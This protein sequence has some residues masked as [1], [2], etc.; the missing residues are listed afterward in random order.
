MR[1]KEL[2]RRLHRRAKNGN[3]VWFLM[4]WSCDSV[5]EPPE[6]ICIGGQLE[7]YIR[8][9]GVPTIPQPKLVL[10]RPVNNTHNLA[11]LFP[12]CCRVIRIQCK[13]RFCASDFCGVDVQ[14]SNIDLDS[15][16]T[17]THLFR[18]STL[19]HIQKT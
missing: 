18:A 8:N 13:C 15:I 5:T 4:V 16:I 11:K 17:S 7:H 14:R 9:S 1:Q 2:G 19:C 10:L 12:Q 6:K 3:Y